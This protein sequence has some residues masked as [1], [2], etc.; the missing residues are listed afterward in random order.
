[1]SHDDIRRL[2]DQF[3]RV[4]ADIQDAG[5]G[6]AY[7]YMNVAPD[8]PPGLPELL[9]ECADAGLIL[10]IVRSCGQKHADAAH[11]IGL[12][13]IGGNGHCRRAAEKRK[14]FAPPHPLPRSRQ[15]FLLNASWMKS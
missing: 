11:S 12:L 7:V 13:R 4:P 8:I 9:K 2:R 6:P 10:L 1:M 14:E 15:S 3:A 5:T